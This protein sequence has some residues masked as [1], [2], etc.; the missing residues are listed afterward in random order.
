[1]YSNTDQAEIRSWRFSDFTLAALVFDKR[2][3]PIGLPS[4]LT[5]QQEDLER[6]G[7]DKRF[8]CNRDYSSVDVAGTEHL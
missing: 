2:F 3:Q 1:M 4:P 8:D 6:S 7:W 5:Q